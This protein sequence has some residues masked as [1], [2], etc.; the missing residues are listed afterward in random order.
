M[1]R[2]QGVTAGPRATKQMERHY[3]QVDFL[4]VFNIIVL[5]FILLKSLKLVLENQ[6][7]RFIMIGLT[8]QFSAIQH[9]NNEIMDRTL[10]FQV[11]KMVP[12]GFHNQQFLWNYICFFIQ[13]VSPAWYTN[14]NSINIQNM[15]ES[16]NK[17]I[18]R[19]H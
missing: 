3:S 10:Y 9:D 1:L 15:I 5:V 19:L 17:L 14:T 13:F 18:P 2:V 12:I 6:G 7:S 4:R 8:W 11:F 16:K